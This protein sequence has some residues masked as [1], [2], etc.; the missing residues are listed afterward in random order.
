MKKFSRSPR[1]AYPSLRGKFP[2]KLTYLY[3]S[4]I[5]NV[6]TV[7][8][9]YCSTANR[10]PAGLFILSITYLLL[11]QNANYVRKIAN[12]FQQQS[13]FASAEDVRRKIL[14]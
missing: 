7:F 14:R 8:I 5:G 13:P 12:I 4:R 6:G 9:Y 2:N 11:V 10:T 1:I 3:W